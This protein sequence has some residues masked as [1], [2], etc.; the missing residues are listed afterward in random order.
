MTTIANNKKKQEHKSFSPS[1]NIVRDA[2]SMLHYIPTT[3]SK[4]VFTQLIN[5]Y[6]VGIRSFT[7]VGAY[8]IGKSAFLWAFEKNINHQQHFFSKLSSNMLAKEFDFLR[9]VGQYNSLKNELANQIGISSKE[10]T[11][12]TLLNALDK[13]YKALSKSNKGLVIAVD[14]FGKFLEYAAKN[15]PEDELYFIQQLA[16]YVNDTKKNIFFITTLH[17]DFNGYA[18]ALTKSQQN[19]W[20][21]VKGRL[22]EVTFN[23]PVE[24]LL[25]L[26]SERLAELKLGQKDK[27]FSK[28][29]KS[30]ETAKVF[31][32][33]DYFIES[34]AE[35]LLPFDILTAA[36]LTLS[37]QKYG[38]NERSL[39]SFIESNDHLGIREYH[40]NQ[41]P[42]Y[43]LASLYDYLVYNFHSLLTTKFNPHYTQWA[44]MRIAIER[45]E[46]LLEDQVSDALKLVKAI[47]LLNIFTTAAASINRAFL[48]E[49]GKY[50]LGIK[51][52]ETIITKLEK[53]KIIRF[54]N[55]SNKFILFEGTDLDIEL[56]INE[57]GNLVERVVNTVHHLNKYFDFPFISAKAAYYE[58]GTPRLFTFRLSEEPLIQAPENEIDGIINLI[59]SDKLKDKDIRSISENNEEAILYGL[60]KNTDEIKN[61]LFEIEKIEKVKEANNEDRVA[62]REL[63]S[64][65][66]HQVK[67]LNHYVLA[68]IYAGVESSIVWFFK[69]KK[70]IISDEKSFNQL[71]SRIC[72]EVYPDT[73]V[74]KNEMVNKT[75]L[76]G[77]LSVAKKNLLKNLTEYWNHNE[78]GFDTTKFPPEKTVYL[79]LLRNTGIHQHYKEGV[80]LTEPTDATFY[81]L[82]H[83]SIHFLESTRTGKRSLKEFVDIL[84]ARPFKLKKGFIDFW[85][86]IFLFTRRDDFALFGADGYIP[87]LTDDTLELISR[88][89]VGYDL[90]AFDIEGV[91]LNIFN[92]Y[93][94]LLNQSEQER[95]TNQTFIETIKPF[96]VFYRDLPNYA[97]NTKSLGKKTLALREAI[98]YSK[99]PEETFFEQFPKALGFTIPQLQKGEREL[100]AF[101]SQL[102]QSIREI[103]TCFDELVNNFETFIQEDILGN[104]LGFPRYKDNLQQRF[105]G[106]KRHLLL[107]HQRVFVQRI[108]SELDD[109]KAWLNSLAQACIGKSLE[110]MTDEE[111]PLLVE[112][113]KDTVHELDNLSD[114]SKSGFDENKEIA[115]KF[116]VTSFVKGLQR[117]LVRLPKTKNKELIQLQSVVKAKL[118]DDRQLNIAMLAQLLEELIRDE[119]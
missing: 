73:P 18:R 63:N 61:L 97:K 98:A 1:V 49:Y 23:E 91:K 81:Q 36:V 48:I 4:Q 17:Q 12:N 27:Q 85:V 22:K 35:K 108:Q 83:T 11:T 80:V 102:Q 2:D 25:F 87:T 46:G 51:Q 42:Y 38:Q 43:N 16:E 99:N 116:E 34:F 111:W 54:V 118:S 56:A 82:W 64:I 5:D 78:L 3:N 6:Q 50:S 26:A 86:P 79:S 37:L 45:T 8:G 69:G 76:S 88:D 39:F 92:R 95:P 33:K 24:Q 106:L 44:A 47:G 20:D 68:N 9:I 77:A 112:K 84:L 10:F 67:L 32:L 60:Y 66:Q 113:F 101:V 19:E 30:I 90:K 93:R 28:L 29:F 114:I 65:L 52:P 41:T 94:A 70:Q 14:E 110:M 21:K 72:N 57:A 105:S 31:P 119:K 71:L 15:N 74:F 104:K 109:R 7:I 55:H 103:R 96:L 75:K 62:L 40:N 107:P 53:L 59:F 89:P 100:V 58:K 117:N 115:V 13:R